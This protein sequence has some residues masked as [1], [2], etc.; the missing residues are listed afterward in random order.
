MPGPKLGELAW[1]FPVGLGWYSR[2]V[3]QGDRIYVGSPG[4]HTTSLCLD[5]KTGEEIWKSTQCHERAGVY[6]I[7]PIAWTQH[8]AKYC[9]KPN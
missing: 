5:L 7:R 3:I 6:N 2:P 4:M 8:P 9:G 1:K